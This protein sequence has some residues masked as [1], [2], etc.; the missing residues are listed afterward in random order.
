MIEYIPEAVDRLVP[1]YGL[2]D[3]SEGLEG[4]EETVNMFLPSYQRGKGAELLSK[5]QQNL[6]LTMRKII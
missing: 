3:R 1:D 5:S 6:I 4:R 2:L